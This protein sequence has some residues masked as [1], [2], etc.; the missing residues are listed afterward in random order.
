MRRTLAE[1]AKKGTIENSFGSDKS[2]SSGSNQDNNNHLKV[3]NKKI[4]SINESAR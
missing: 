1:I 3:G 2:S 4:I